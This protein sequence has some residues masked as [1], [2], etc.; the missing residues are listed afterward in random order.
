VRVSTPSHF[1]VLPCE[2]P[3][4]LNQVL[5]VS[6]KFM[7]NVSSPRVRL[8]GWGREPPDR[9]RNHRISIGGISRW[10]ELENHSFP[11]QPLGAGE[12]FLCCSLV[13]GSGSPVSFSTRTF[14]N[15]TSPFDQPSPQLRRRREASSVACR[16]TSIL[17]P[18]RR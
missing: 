3:T 6:S 11:A 7:R 14:E 1:H 16:N 5:K 9:R 13:L 4:N 18:A 2:T 15:S 8:P 10:R 12:V 17:S